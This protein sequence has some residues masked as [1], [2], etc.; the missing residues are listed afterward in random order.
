[1]EFSEETSALEMAM[2]ISKIVDKP[3]LVMHLRYKAIIEKSSLSR[4][5]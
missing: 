1:M 2:E 5:R 3:R 4:M